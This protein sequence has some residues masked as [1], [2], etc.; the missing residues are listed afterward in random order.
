M[1]LVGFGVGGRADGWADQITE[2]PTSY[3]TPNK[4]Y[5]YI[6]TSLGVVLVEGVDHPAELPLVQPRA[7][8][9]QRLIR[10]CLVG[11]SRIYQCINP[12]TTTPTTQTN[13]THYHKLACVT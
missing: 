11:M 12:Y 4:L 9:A 1:H 6:R 10:W 7:P 5:I 13:T 3:V 8:D 2:G